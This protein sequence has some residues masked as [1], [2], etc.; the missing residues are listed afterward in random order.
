MMLMTNSN[1]G[2][3]E[4]H[5]RGFSEIQCVKCDKLQKILES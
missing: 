3:S 2:T 1:N 4:E 5:I